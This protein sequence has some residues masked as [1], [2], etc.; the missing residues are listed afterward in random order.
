[1]VGIFFAS[2]EHGAEDVLVEGGVPE[3]HHP[4]ID[5][6]FSTLNHPAIKGDPTMTMETHS[7]R[8]HGT[9]G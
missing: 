6:P 5:V 9:D 4:C 7:K 2:P 8:L 1:M 3:F